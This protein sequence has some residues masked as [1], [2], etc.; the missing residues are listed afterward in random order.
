MPV[1]SLTL[2]EHLDPLMVETRAQPVRKR[3][4]LSAEEGGIGL[5]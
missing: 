2:L 3:L 5:Q 1:H 4:I